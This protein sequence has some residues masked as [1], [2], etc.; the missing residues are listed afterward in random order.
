MTEYR[1][2]PIG[3]GGS[4][5][6]ETSSGREKMCFCLALEDDSERLIFDLN[7]VYYLPNSLCNL[8]SLACLNDNDIYYDNENKALYHCITQRVLAQAKR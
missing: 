3:V 7:D 2:Q 1:E 4:T 6:I 8:V 5:L